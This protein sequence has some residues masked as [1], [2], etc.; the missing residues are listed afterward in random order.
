MGQRSI[1]IFYELESRP[2]HSWRH[3]RAVL[4]ALHRWL[5]PEL[6]PAL[7]FAALWHDAVYDPKA[8]DNEER[9]AD[10]CAEYL[11]EAGADE[12]TGARA[13]ALIDRKSVV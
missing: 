2:Y 11:R 9:S 6:P 10:L 1:R 12:A 7:E 5:G 13:V 4:G 8:S 3:V